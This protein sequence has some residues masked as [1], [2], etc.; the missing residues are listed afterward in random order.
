MLIRYPYD[1][2][3]ARQSASTAD[4][5]AEDSTCRATR[6]STCRRSDDVEAPPSTAPA[7]PPPDGPGRSGAGSWHGAVGRPAPLGPARGTE[8]G[9][10]RGG[11]R[12]GLHQCSRVSR[13]RL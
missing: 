4:A 2:P 3:P 1:A 9:L 5:S 10:G 8:G 11:G 12:G 7:A 13:I 6:S